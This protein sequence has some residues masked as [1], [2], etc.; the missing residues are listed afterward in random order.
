MVL[1]Q[2]FFLDFR[3]LTRFSATFDRQKLVCVG[4]PVREAGRTREWIRVLPYGK[5]WLV[6]RV[7]AITLRK[8][9]S[10]KFFMQV[11]AAVL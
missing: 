4:L 10:S 7:I 11:A 6:A 3:S 1:L 5:G 8:E 9:A 2:G